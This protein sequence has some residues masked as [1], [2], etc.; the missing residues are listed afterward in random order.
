MTSRNQ[1]PESRNATRHRASAAMPGIAPL[2]AT[3]ILEET[4]ETRQSRLSVWALVLFTCFALFGGQSL[5]AWDNTKPRVEA[6][7]WICKPDFTNPNGCAEVKL[8]L[9]GKVTKTSMIDGRFE[10]LNRLS[11]YNVHGRINSM[12]V[13]SQPVANTSHPCYA[14]VT[15]NP[16]TNT[17][18]AGPPLNA[19]YATVDGTC[20][21]GS[22]SFHVTLVDDDSPNHTADWACDIHMHGTDKKGKVEN[23]DDAGQPFQRGTVEV[24]P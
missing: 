16:A 3:Q 6:A 11:K 17:Q 9:T 22:C 19:P 18:V 14:A 4:M 7:G 8:G 12:V 21:D 20:E 1:L 13:N 24:H 23:Y 5:F 15:F 10:Y 2:E